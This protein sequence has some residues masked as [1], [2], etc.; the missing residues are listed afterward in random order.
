MDL[1]D[2]QSHVFNL[3]MQWSLISGELNSDGNPLSPSV[4]LSLPQS[5]SVSLSLTLFPQLARPTGSVLTL[6]LM[7]HIVEDQ[8]IQF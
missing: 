2:H 1:D 6:D 7:R 5:P 8:T 4:F 3:T